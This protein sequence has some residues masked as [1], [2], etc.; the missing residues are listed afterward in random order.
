MIYSCTTL[1]FSR[2]KY[3]ILTFCNHAHAS[4]CPTIYQSRICMYFV[5]NNC[6]YFSWTYHFLTIDC[7][8]F[9]LHQSLGLRLQNSINDFIFLKLFL[10]GSKVLSSGSRRDS[11]QPGQTAPCSAAAA[12]WARPRP[13]QPRAQAHGQRHHRWPDCRDPAEIHKERGETLRLRR[14]KCVGQFMTVVSLFRP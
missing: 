7:E 9:H 2:L 3:R 13:H 14:H 6:T 10:L 1:H 5:T 11:G 12:G 8:A 4:M